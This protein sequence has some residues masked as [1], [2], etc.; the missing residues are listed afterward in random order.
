LA[1]FAVQNAVSLGLICKEEWHVVE[2]K[3]RVEVGNRSIGDN[4]DIEG[5]VLQTF[6]HLFLVTQLI[7]GKDLY[8]ELAWQTLFQLSLQVMRHDCVGILGA[9]G[10]RPAD[11]QR[12]RCGCRQASRAV[13]LNIID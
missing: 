3:H 10:C 8:V 2:L 11:T 4:A 6:E 9:V 7:V 5:A 1:D 12:F 13:L